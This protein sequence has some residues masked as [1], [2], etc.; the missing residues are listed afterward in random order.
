MISSWIE[1]VMHDVIDHQCNS[2]E[3]IK[4]PRKYDFGGPLLA[5]WNTLGYTPIVH[6]SRGEWESRDG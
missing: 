2:M 6:E 1:E 3:F 4:T 5:H